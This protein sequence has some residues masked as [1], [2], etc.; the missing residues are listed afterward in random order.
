MSI[1]E[2]LE[3]FRGKPPVRSPDRYIA[4]WKETDA[5]DEKA[6]DAFVLILRT[7]GCSWAWDSGGCTMC[8]YVNDSSTNVREKELEIQLEKAMAAYSGEPYVKIFTSGS[9]LDTSEVPASFAEKLVESFGASASRILIESRPEYVT[10]ETLSPLKDH[11]QELEIA[12]GLESANDRVR[13]KGI[14]KGFTF[15]DYMRA[16]H[17]VKDEGLISKTYLLLKPPFLTEKE[18]PRDAVDSIKVVDE[19]TETISLNP[20]NIQNRTLVEYLWRRGIYRPP[21][22]WTLLEALKTPTKSR[23][24][25]SPTA[26]GGNRGTHNC[27]KC[28]QEIIKRISEFSITQDREL[29][30]AN[31]SCKNDWQA[32]MEAEEFMGTTADI[33]KILERTTEQSF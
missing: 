23:L 9:F 12:L 26:G 21:W 20:V 25:S 19:T 18:A 16:I 1:K 29:L 30:N 10:P 5:I 4:A 11:A 8:G 17:T 27:G 15:E 13:L 24:M 33:G 7:R 28:D 2:V 14:N 3:A 22:L 32:F 6:I 31:C